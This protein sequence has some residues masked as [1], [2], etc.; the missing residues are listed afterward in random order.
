MRRG[1]KMDEH[2]TRTSEAGDADS[3]NSA[4]PPRAF[5]Q[6][7]RSRRAVGAAWQGE[8]GRDRATHL[9]A[10]HGFFLQLADG[11]RP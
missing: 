4:V 1:L 7:R 11:P 5:S 9:A 2:F 3:R 8:M 6:P 10:Q